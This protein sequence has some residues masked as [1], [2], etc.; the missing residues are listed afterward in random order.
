MAKIGFIA[1][2]FLTKHRSENRNDYDMCYCVLILN[3]IL[4][5]KNENKI[6]Y[7]KLIL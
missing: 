5:T 3:L 4:E 2:F 7:F 1:Q 6:S